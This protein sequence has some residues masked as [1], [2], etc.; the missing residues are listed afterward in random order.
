MI[1][2]LSGWI[3]VGNLT[4]GENKISEENNKLNH[5][6]LSFVRKGLGGVV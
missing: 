1:F 5:P 2:I 6:N 3:L 4:A